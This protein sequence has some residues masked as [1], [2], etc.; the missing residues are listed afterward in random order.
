MVVLQY[1]L[2]ITNCLRRDH[3]Y[4]ILQFDLPI[5]VMKSAFLFTSINFS[6][7]FLFMTHFYDFISDYG[8]SSGHL[9]WC[10]FLDLWIAYLISVTIRFGVFISWFPIKCI[11]NACLVYWALH[12]C[13]YILCTHMHVLTWCGHLPHHLLNVYVAKITA[14]ASSHQSTR[15]TYTQGYYTHAGAHNWRSVNVFVS[16]LLFYQHMSVF[17][18][19]LT[20][21]LPF[22]CTVN[23]MLKSLLKREIRHPKI[24][25]SRVPYRMY[26]AILHW[27]LEQFINLLNTSLL[28][29]L[30]IQYVCL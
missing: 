20:S 4:Y 29:S 15:F 25:V 13:L 21:L 19:G 16:F 22:F 24:V 8:T 6:N 5:W 17:Y 14:I 23:L 28:L 30:I 26:V 1:L 18:T 9:M 27:I 2:S 11:T 7:F 12:A 3:F 10:A